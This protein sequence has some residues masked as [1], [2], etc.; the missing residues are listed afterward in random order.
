M[1]LVVCV[2]GVK[3]TFLECKVRKILYSPGYGAGWSTWNRSEDGL[4]KFVLEY[5]PIISF[6]EKGGKFN[7]N[8]CGDI[9]GNGVHPLLEQLQTDARARFS[10]DT[11]ICVLGADTLRVAKVNGLVRI[12]EYDGYE[13]IESPGDVEWM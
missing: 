13:S 7:R 5:E 2:K 9:N 8:D 1:P 6:I 11:Y 10:E 4:A 12:N 3:T